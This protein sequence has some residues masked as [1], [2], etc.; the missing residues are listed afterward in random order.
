MKSETATTIIIV[1]LGIV[2]L[3]MLTAQHPGLS[4]NGYI[5]YPEKV[6]KNKSF[7]IK[8]FDLNPG[9]QYFL[10]FNKKL[11]RNIT[12]STS[13]MYYVIQINETTEIKLVDNYSMNLDT[14]TIEV[15][16]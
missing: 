5:E 3:L 7:T 14:I 2:L 8:I 15:Y 4:K 9:E 10:Y 1:F 11:A 13:P 12:A 6:K 16:R